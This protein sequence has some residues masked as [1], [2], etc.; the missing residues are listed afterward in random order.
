MCWRLR[1]ETTHREQ[2]CSHTL[3][4]AEKYCGQDRVLRFWSSKKV[5]WES[6]IRI[7]RLKPQ[8][9]YI[10]F[11]A[12]HEGDKAKVNIT[13]Y[14]VDNVTI[15][16]STNK[17]LYT[18]AQNSKR[19]T[20]S[21]D[22]RI[23]NLFANGSAF[24]IAKFGELGLGLGLGLVLWSWLGSPLGFVW[25]QG[26]IATPTQSIEY[27][28]VRIEDGNVTGCWWHSS[29]SAKAW[30]RWHHEY[31]NGYMKVHLS[32]RKPGQIGE[33]IHW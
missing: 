14:D 1:H 11:D 7:T 4:S 10:R 28:F 12:K 6:G 31:T 32:K 19:K 33:H 15:S 27:G 30:R 29:I 8:F 20:D 23:S 22:L 24:A 13:G 21:V 26:I 9:F 17:Y 3:S 25:F 5:R 18:S 2:W 16:R